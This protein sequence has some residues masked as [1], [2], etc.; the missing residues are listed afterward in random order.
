MIKMENKNKVCKRRPEETKR[1]KMK[2][3]NR[4]KEKVKMIEMEEGRKKLKGDYGGEEMERRNTIRGI[5]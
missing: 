4:N 5:R 3:K 2:K 1:E